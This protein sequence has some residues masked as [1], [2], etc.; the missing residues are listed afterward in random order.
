MPFRKKRAG[1]EHLSQEG[2]CSHWSN[3]ANV[4][5]WTLSS[6]HV[7]RLDFSASND[8]HVQSYIRSISSMRR[9]G[10]HC[11][12]SNF[13]HARFTGI[14]ECRGCPSGCVLI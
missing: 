11:K 3:L 6:S 8:E 12:Y 2:T 9:G 14:H 13:P 5:G 7:D 4:A 1:H 10:L